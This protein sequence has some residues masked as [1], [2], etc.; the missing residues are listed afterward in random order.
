ME[1]VP[2]IVGERLRAAG[3]QEHPDAA[4]LTAFSERS[5]PTQERNSVM[6][7][8]SRCADCREIVS[9]AL[10]EEPVSEMRPQPRSGT[11]LTWP[12]LRWGLV[13]AGIV[14]IAS[15]GV[16]EYKSHT[17]QSMVLNAGPVEEKGAKMAD[18]RPEA[19]SAAS[20][21]D[22]TE[23]TTPSV[24]PSRTRADSGK[25][26]S[27]TKREFDRL[28]QFTFKASAPPRDERAGVAGAIGGPINGRQLSHGPKVLMQQNG[29]NSNANNEA[30]AFQTQPAT[31]PSATLTQELELHGQAAALDGKSA[32][33]DKKT[34]L[35][36]ALVLPPSV[37]VPSATGRTESEV[38]RA[39]PA[40]AAA[41]PQTRTEAENQTTTP[42]G[43]SSGELSNF[44]KSA[45]LTPQ[46]SRWAISAAGTLQRSVDQGKSW[47]DVDVNGS[48]D[49]E[50]GANLQLAMRA[51]RGKA[52]AK[53]KADVKQREV[54]VVFRAVAANGPDVWAGGSNGA[55][56]HSLDGGLHWVRVEPAGSGV[57]LSG[58]ILSLQF[59]DPQRGRILT[60]S[61]EIWTT[62]DGGQTWEKH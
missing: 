26:S 18:N 30:Y 6:E 5:L 51:S 28:T 49:A 59:A 42:Y 40:E 60:S 33:A 37:K 57:V 46:S 43:V 3:V 35:I 52:I 39:K 25:T 55:L 14:A 48:P 47:Q 62:A 61:N 53:D 38:A 12:A 20:E 21:T 22:K 7:H 19:L 29:L 32:D 44:S 36:D 17:R 58:D 1:H 16:V 34:Q 13:A 15:L 23:M 27:E 56:F 54:P 8:L 4:V 2:K 31:P 24:A 9:L 10:P 50:A 41:A 45:T 11:W